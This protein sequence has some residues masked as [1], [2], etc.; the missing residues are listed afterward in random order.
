M[1]KFRF[2]SLARNRL[3]AFGAFA[4][5]FLFISI[6]LMF[7]ANTLQKETNPYFGVVLYVF[8]PTML[9]FSL[10]IIPIGMW[11]QW[12]RW[13]HSERP[14]EVKWPLIDLNRSGHRNAT[15]VFLSGTLAF[16]LL[17]S[18]GMYEAYHFSESVSFCG[19][20][21][22][23]V[24]HPE[25]TAYQ[26]SPHARVPCTACHVGEG[27]DW[28]AKSKIS[29]A[30]Q[31]YAVLA[32]VYPRPLPNPI[33][34]LRPAR[35][36]C[37][38]CHWP[39]ITFGAQQRQ[40]NHFMYDDD[41]TLWTLNMLIKTGGGD[42]QLE[43]LSGIHWHI[44]R[45]IE[46]K[47]IPRDEKRQDIPW[48]QYTDKR[49]GRVEVFQ[50][51]DDPLTEEDILAGEKRTMDCLDCHNRP[52]HIFYSPDYSVDKAIRLR[53][54]D[55]SLPGIKAIAVAAMAKEYETHESALEGIANVIG[56]HY[57]RLGQE[58]AETNAEK[59]EAAIFAVQDEFSSNIFPE[60]KARWSSFPDNIGHFRE[61]GCMRCHA[62]N[63][64]SDTGVK[65]THDCNACH[66]ILSQGR[67]GEIETSTSEEG[68][69]F[70]HPED[71]DEAWREI[72]CYECHDGTQP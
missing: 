2:P 62:G 9:L 58:F 10:L 64:E 45:E 5:L 31:V 72:G 11:R 65:I 29:G 49:T 12:R 19:T 48:V 24:M 67:D 25:Y 61:V 44:N 6:V 57:E 37:E 34:N 15:V 22:H 1:G 35:E 40:F 43:E 36:T 63:H 60:M 53:R 71:I 50:D 28:F 46:I 14:V 38:K 51:V 4:S 55:R 52:S 21:C 32:D 18:F 39:E 70:K 23:S 16:F 30:Y 42:P 7:L 69:E 41:N 3:S 27:A 68:L 20:T 17:S 26:N 47:Y 66:T 13:K 54:I 59:I 56:S 8:L 33:H